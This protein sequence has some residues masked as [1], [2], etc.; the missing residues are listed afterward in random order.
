MTGPVTDD[1][2]TL[3]A[4]Q[5]ALRAGIDERDLRR[6]I[7]RGEVAAFKDGRTW[8]IRVADLE[9]AGLTL[10]DEVGAL[11]RRAEA[12]ERQVARLTA[13]RQE[14]LQENEA[15]RGQLAAAH[16]RHG[17]HLRSRLG[18]R[19]KEPEYDWRVIGGLIETDGE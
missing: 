7:E 11:V 8:R 19:R 17:L 3:S 9:A 5:A 12:A 13:E 10:H 2:G 15:L 1:Q 14:L 6:R 18:L 16:G 4:R